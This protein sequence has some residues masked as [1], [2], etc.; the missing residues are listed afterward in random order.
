MDTRQAAAYLSVSVRCVEQWRF[1][2]RGP[3]YVKIEG[4]VR[5]RRS[6]LDDFMEVIE[7]GGK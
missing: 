3:R 7:P 5:Y 6:D 1:K 2:K 4:S